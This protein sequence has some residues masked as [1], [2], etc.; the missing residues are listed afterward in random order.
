MFG[1]RRK[2]RQW[3]LAGGWEQ[4]FGGWGLQGRMGGGVLVSLTLD[5]PLFFFL[6]KEKLTLD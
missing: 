6:I 4:V 2:R 5:L 1:E 3:T